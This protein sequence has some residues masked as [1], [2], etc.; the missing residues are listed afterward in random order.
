MLTV[1]ELVQNTD[2]ETL[3]FDNNWMKE[4]EKPWELLALA[5]KMLLNNREWN[6]SRLAQVEKSV[7]TIGPVWIGSGTK[8]TGASYIV[9]PTFIGNDCV[10]GPNCFIRPY[11][12]LADEV[13][14]G[15]NCYV[16]NSLICSKTGIFHYCGIS[17]SIIGENCMITSYSQTASARQSQKN[18]MVKIGNQLVDTGL[19]KFGCVIG[20]D[21]YVGSHTLILPG[22]L[23]G[24]NC[25]IGSHLIISENVRDNTSIRVARQEQVQKKG[26]VR[27]LDFT[28][29]KITTK[30]ENTNED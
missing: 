4:L 23:I 5:R 30:G 1:K 2:L 7:V 24:R 16:T 18:V 10:L 28:I 17:R 6:I 3:F 13:I 29:P 27:R 20:S 15:Y 21:T 9:G 11:S 25:R 22:R 12:I 8:I 14:V 26:E 19:N